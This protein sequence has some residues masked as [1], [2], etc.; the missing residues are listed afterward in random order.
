M[1]IRMIANEMTGIV[2]FRDEALRLRSVDS[3]AA[4]EQRG[5]ELAGFKCAEYSLVC[6]LP[7]H[8]ACEGD[9]GIVHRERNPRSVRLRSEWFFSV[10]LCHRGKRQDLQYI[11]G[12][13]CRC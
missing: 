12:S 3:H 4:Q 13:Y 10:R 2:P 6:L 9:V 1:G 11:R 5:V 8:T 7:R